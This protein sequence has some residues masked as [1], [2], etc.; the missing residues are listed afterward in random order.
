MRRL[1]LVV[2]GLLL[3][4]ILLVCGTLEALKTPAVRDRIAAA[5][6]SALGQPVTIGDLTISLLPSPALTA[7]A[8]RIGRSDPGGAADSTAAP[9]LFVREVRVVPRPASLLPGRPLAVDRVDLT[10]M[11]IALRRDRAGHWELPVVPVAGTDTSKAQGPG[12]TLDTLHLRDGAIRIVDDR[13]QRHASTTVSGVDAAM[14]ASAGRV[15][16]PRLS[17]YLGKT[18]VAGAMQ[19]GPTGAEILLRIPSVEAA[20]LPALFALAGMEPY[21][22]LS[23][24]GKAPV[25]MT[26][27]TSPDFASHTATGEASLDKARLDALSLENLRTTF[28]LDERGLL[29]LDPLTFTAYEVAREAR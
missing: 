13:L 22:G 19:V 15:T 12:F 9:G 6:S 8:V 20:D 24:A 11:V 16:M 25:S 2:G 5:L 23:I 10:G 3:L 18:S 17:G 14:H 26:V 7:R 1:L 27:R 29:T 4:L 21:P 28:R